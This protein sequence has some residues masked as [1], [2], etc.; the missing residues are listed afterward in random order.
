VAAG[1]ALWSDADA[2]FDERSKRCLAEQRRAAKARREDRTPEPEPDRRHFSDETR[3]RMREAW[4]RR[5]AKQVAHHPTTEYDD[6]G[7]PF[8]HW[9]PVP[10]RRFG[11]AAGLF[12]FTAL[13]RL[14]LAPAR[15]PLTHDPAHRRLLAAR[16]LAHALT[17]RPRIPNLG[18]TVVGTER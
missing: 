2:P 17:G 7:T 8:S 9:A 13:G 14:Y 11:T 6:V 15:R 5:K 4:A 3:R 10:A 18:G 12:H 16:R 1:Q